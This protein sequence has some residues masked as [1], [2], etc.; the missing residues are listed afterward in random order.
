[1]LET[2]FGLHVDVLGDA[3]LAAGRLA[4][5]GYTTLVVPD[6]DDALGGLGPA[7]LAQVQAFVRGGGR[8][9]GWRARGIGI[10]GA[11]GLTPARAE[12]AARLK[13]PGT[14][15]E[16]VLDAASPL[17]WGTTGR[18]YALDQADPVLRLGAGA[19][20]RY[21][22]AGALWHSGY[23]AGAG[24]LGNTPAVLDE[25]FGSGDVVLFTFDPAF[26]GYADGTE[27]LVANALL[28]PRAG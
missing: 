12:T 6:G 17:A 15:V 4:T 1:V 27:R 9:I 26:R 24:A 18:V 14:A 22:P 19:V 21:P 10:A 2:R 28:A 23:L 7:A 13:A 25:P 20:G 16:V 8:Y 3:E 5:G 11:A